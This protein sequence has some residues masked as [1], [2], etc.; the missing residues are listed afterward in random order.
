MEF[1]KP[2]GDSPGIQ[3]TGTAC[4]TY[5]IHKKKRKTMKTRSIV[6]V[7][8]SMALAGIAMMGLMLIVSFL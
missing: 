2:G 5:T 6:A 3:A 4:A 7:E 1:P 8:I